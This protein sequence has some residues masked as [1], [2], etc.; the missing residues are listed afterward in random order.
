MSLEKWY[1]NILTTR[2]HALW[3]SKFFL[4]RT[5]IQRHN[6]LQ[7]E[8]LVKDLQI[9]QYFIFLF[10]KIFGCRMFIFFAILHQKNFSQQIGRFRYLFLLYF[11]LLLIAFRRKNNKN[12]SNNQ[13]IFLE[14]FWEIFFIIK[15][16]KFILHFSHFISQKY[17]IKRKN[18]EFF[19]YVTSTK[20]S[21]Q[22]HKAIQFLQREHFKDI[23]YH[24]IYGEIEN[25]ENFLIVT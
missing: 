24:K 5:K 21:N 9:T 3:L 20:K 12:I 2:I 8:I 1:K 11:L 15:K 4:I 23:N 25:L 22:K 19:L 6:T 16:V 14:K 13:I 18:L 17:L 10:A 7:L